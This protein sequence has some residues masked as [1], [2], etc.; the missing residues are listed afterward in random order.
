M[1]E[2]FVMRLR[3]LVAQAG[4]LASAHTVLLV[5]SDT[6]LALDLE[7]IFQADGWRVRTAGDG[8][9]ALAE[10][11]SREHTPVILMDARLEGAP[12]LLAAILE[13]GIHRHCPIAVIAEHVSDEWIAR[14]REG[15]I[16][17]IVPRNADTAAWKNHLSTMQRGHRLL[18][19]LEELRATSLSELQQD[20]LTG[21]FSRETMLTLLFRETDRVQRLRGTLCLML[22]DIDD[23]AHWNKEL[24]REACDEL[25]R[26]VSARTVRLLRSYDLLGRVGPDEFLL[27]LPGCGTANALMLAERLRIE[28]FGEPF[29]VKMG[30]TEGISVQLTASF[31]IAASRGRSPVVVIREAEQT[32]ALAR[33]TAP[34][35]IRCAGESQPG[36]LHL[37][38]D[39]VVLV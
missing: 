14:L 33:Q 7:R 32:L 37:S 19:E 24:G 20:R 26:D 11:E 4:L 21:L 30:R 13:S 8:A 22:F 5:S 9:T 6:L 35:T 31:G 29:A 12:Q 3:N 38:M 1:H 15:A 2:G 18:C 36:A 10:L 34:D 17:D 25:L 23:F 27:A 16:D 28:V 39:N